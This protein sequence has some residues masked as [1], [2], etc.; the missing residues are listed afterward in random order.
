MLPQI[1]HE[2]PSRV[3]DW[4]R[5]GSTKE[6]SFEQGRCVTPEAAFHFAHENFCL[7]IHNSQPSSKIRAPT[8]MM[9]QASDS[10]GTGICLA[11]KKEWFAPAKVRPT[12]PLNLCGKRPTTPG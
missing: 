2:E 12:R 10:E 6:S 3:C 11:V 7:L 1:K 5:T 9:L 4:S 8:T